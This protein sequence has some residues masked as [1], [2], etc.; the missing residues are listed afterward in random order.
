MF[1]RTGQATGTIARSSKVVTRIG[2][3]RIAT[4]RPID[5]KYIT[6]FSCLLQT[7]LKRNLSRQCARG[8]ELIE[9]F[10]TLK[11]CSLLEE[12][13]IR[14][15]FFFL[16]LQHKETAKNLG[17]GQSFPKQTRNI[18]TS[19]VYSLDILTNTYDTGEAGVGTKT[20][21]VAA[22]FSC[23]DFGRH[24][25]PSQEWTRHLQENATPALPHAL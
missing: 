13:I 6:A 14:S 17:G 5:Q 1:T 2:R 21:T 16:A 25:M 23:I 4:G 20:L 19:N 8:T 24:G 18:L 15:L 10:L 3:N 9:N 7:R 12:K 22:G 11:T